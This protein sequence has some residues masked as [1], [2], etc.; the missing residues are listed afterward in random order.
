[1][2]ESIDNSKFDVHYVFLNPTVPP[3]AKK[4]IAKGFHVD[5][6][7][8]QGKRDAISAAFSL[9]QLLVKNRPD[10]IHTHLFDASFIALP[11]ARLLGIKKRIHTRH[12]STFHHQYHPHAVK[13]D[14]LIN[15]CSTHIVAITKNVADILIKQENVPTSKVCIVNHGFDFTAFDNISDDRL[16]VLKTKYNPQKKHPV[17]GVISRFTEWKGIQFIL[18]AF[19]KLL[20]DYPDSLLV[21]ANAN[22][23]YKSE[24][25]VLLKQLPDNSYCI[26]GFEP[27]VMALYSFFD[28][29]VHVPVDAQS[30]AFGQVYVEALAA[31]LPCVYT[32]S[33]VAN[34][35]IVD[36]VNAVVVPFKN[37]DAIYHALLKILTDPDFATSIAKQASMDVR[38]RFDI[39]RMTVELQKLYES[40]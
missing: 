5:V 2:A 29:F 19:K 18:P 39:N 12:H 28:V 24:I 31:K 33:G 14:R 8:Y 9:L 37:E 20:Q 15:S 3:I 11:V 26:V 23:D 16:A 38:Q 36:G 25:E 21:L 27:D 10:I 30:E 34:D 1:M 22:G 17:I 32:L 35:F 40:L 13:Y 4:F 7:H 6:I